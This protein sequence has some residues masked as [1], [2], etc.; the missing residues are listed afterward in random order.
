MTSLRTAERLESILYRHALLCRLPPETEH[1]AIR[2]KSVCMWLNHSW[3][4]VR[5]KQQLLAAYGTTLAPWLVHVGR[6]HNVTSRKFGHFPLSISLVTLRHNSPFPLFFFLHNFFV[7]LKSKWNESKLTI[8]IKHL[9]F[10]NMVF[11]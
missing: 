4:G 7:I 9:S 2:C 10:C 11:N 3:L 8:Q 5:R 1:T 6:P